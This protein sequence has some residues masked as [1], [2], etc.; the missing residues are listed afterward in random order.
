[1]A[2]S[3]QMSKNPWRQMLVALTRGTDEEIRRATC[4][5]I[6]PPKRNKPYRNVLHAELY[7]D[8]AGPVSL[9]VPTRGVLRILILMR[10][11]ISR[12]KAQTQPASSH[13]AYIPHSPYCLILV[14]A[15]GRGPA[16]PL[17]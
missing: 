17:Q 11:T 7:P 12:P 16:Q 15:H 4:Y 13:E 8:G 10:V 9:C 3:F 5:C 14:H 2:V 1:M 6:A